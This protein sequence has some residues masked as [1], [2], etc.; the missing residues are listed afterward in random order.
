MENIH[1][2]A[3]LLAA[4]DG[5]L[6]LVD[7]GFSPEY[8][9]GLVTS[10]VQEDIHKIP[11]AIKNLGFDPGCIRKVI[12]THLHWDHTG[13][14]HDFPDARFYIQADEFRGLFQLNPNEETYFCPDHWLD[15]LPQVELLEGDHELSP[16]LRLIRTGGHTKG[17][18]ILEVQTA[19]GVIILAGDAPFNYDLL[20]K[21]ISPEGWK[22]FRD[23]PGA[24]FYWD[25]AVISRLESWVNQCKIAGPVQGSTVP[26]N[27]FKKMGKPFYTIHDPRLLEG[28]FE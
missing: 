20:W 23:G 27:H 26:W 28:K 9:P 21:M 12:M 13:A 18:Q 8:I 2:F 16:G 22:L 6:L 19:S 1:S 10:S 24:R 11:A 17:H 5:E 25:S 14:M 15:L 3:F 4:E 7:T